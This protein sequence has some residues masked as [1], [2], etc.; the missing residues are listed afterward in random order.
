LRRWMLLFEIGAYDYIFIH[1]EAAPLG[2]PVFEWL[3]A[4]VFKKKIIYDFDDAIWIP[5]TSKE[6]KLAAWLKAFGKVKHICKWSY[7]ISAGNQFLVNFA[8]QYNEHVVLMPTCVDTE[9]GHKAVKTSFP[10]KPVV[11]WTGSHSTLFYL[12][13]IMPVIK[14]LQEEIDFEFLVIA[15]RKPDLDLKDFRY[16]KWNAATENEDL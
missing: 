7:K 12:N 15:D 14:S 4:K 8:K 6:N 10:D 9:T 3:A 5:N 2:P 1:R 16:V 13:E 11:G